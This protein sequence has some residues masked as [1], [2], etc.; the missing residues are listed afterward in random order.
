MKTIL[1]E[2]LAAT[3]NETNWFVPLRTAVDGLS[4]EY[5]VWKTANIDN[6][7][8]QIVY[9][10][11]FWNKRYLHRFKGL[12]IPAMEGDNDSTFVVPD[13]M[14]WEELGGAVDVVLTE[15]S[16]AIAGAD[17]Q[18]LSQP[19]FPDRETTWLDVI[20]NI[21]IHNAYHIGQIVFL[22]KLQGSWDREK[23]VS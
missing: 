20:A 4:A 6:S 21:S 8:A 16:Q 23:G 19:V 18:K 1:L 11:F 13:T 7:I 5:A 9:H 2:Q 15:L 3:H 14:S 10:L 12:D 22:R 17:E